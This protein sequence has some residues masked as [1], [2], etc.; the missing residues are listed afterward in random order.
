MKETTEVLEEKK[1]SEYFYNPGTGSISKHAIKV[2]KKIHQVR[3]IDLTTY[4]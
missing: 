3:S 2:K 4:N 1:T